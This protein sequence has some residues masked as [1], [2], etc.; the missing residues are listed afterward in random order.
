MAVSLIPDGGSNPTDDFILPVMAVKSNAARFCQSREARTKIVT[1][2][3]A[4]HP[5]LGLRT[6]Y[7]LRL[8]LGGTT[9]V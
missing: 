6:I 3:G 2:F 5:R 7:H 1:I 9:P 8:D 4:L